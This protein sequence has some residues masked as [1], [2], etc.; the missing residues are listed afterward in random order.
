VEVIEDS[1]IIELG[2]KSKN[3]KTVSEEWIDA[4]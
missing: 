4:D 1:N 3:K 2:K